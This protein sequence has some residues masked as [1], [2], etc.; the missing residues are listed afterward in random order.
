MLCQENSYCP[1]GLAAAQTEGKRVVK[2]SSE[3]GSF[4]NRVISSAIYS[5]REDWERCKFSGTK[6]KVLHLASSVYRCLPDIEVEISST[7][8]DMGIW[9]FREHCDRRERHEFPQKW[10]LKIP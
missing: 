3:G 8:L 1:H 5:D 7:Q 4:S 9:Y 2:A 10:Y 6:L